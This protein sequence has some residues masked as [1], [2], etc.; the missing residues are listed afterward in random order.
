MVE[1]DVFD[2]E[3]LR[4]RCS[5]P[6]DEPF[7]GAE[8]SVQQ[9]LCDATPNDFRVA[10]D[11]T[12]FFLNKIT[13]NTPGTQ[14]TDTSAPTEL[15]AKA[16]RTSPEQNSKPEAPGIEVQCLVLRKLNDHILQY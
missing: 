16:S 3:T 6:R 9:S 7:H 11:W 4:F 5:F 12:S 2:P 14:T 10:P 1:S 8:E 15:E 13:A